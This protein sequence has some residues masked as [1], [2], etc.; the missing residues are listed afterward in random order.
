MTMGDILKSVVPVGWP[1]A[2]TPPANA[3]IPKIASSALALD[4]ISIPH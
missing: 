2:S 3:R 4:D 1:N